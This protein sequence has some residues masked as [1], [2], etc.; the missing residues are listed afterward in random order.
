MLNDLE[1]RD[2]CLYEDQNAVI[3][4]LYSAYDL[5]LAEKKKKYI[6]FLILLIIFSLITITA[7]FYFSATKPFQYVSI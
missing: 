5:E 2:A 4:G 7:I 1:K 6:P 3:D